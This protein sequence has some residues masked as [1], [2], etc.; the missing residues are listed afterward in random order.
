YYGVGWFIK[1]DK[2]N[3]VNIWHTGQGDYSYS[4]LKIYPKEKIISIF[5]NLQTK[6]DAKKFQKLNRT[7][8]KLIENYI[9]FTSKWKQIV[10]NSSRMQK[11][12]R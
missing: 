9:Q 4:H 7:L 5:L 2:N 11:N 10:G 1:L 12:P 6:T 8:E 3:I